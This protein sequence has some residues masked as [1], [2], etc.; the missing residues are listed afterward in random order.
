M[1]YYCA[2]RSCLCRSYALQQPSVKLI[3]DLG[4]DFFRRRLDNFPQVQE[5]IISALLSA[6]E[7]FRYATVWSLL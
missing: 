5:K 3:W 2:T 1:R 7:N 4:N 6:M